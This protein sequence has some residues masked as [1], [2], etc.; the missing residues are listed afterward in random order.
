MMANSKKKTRAKQENILKK[1]LHVIPI[2][3]ISPTTYNLC[4]TLNNA[5]NKLK[6]VII[7]TMQ[8]EK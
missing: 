2:W 3:M 5:M 4:L 1:I 8:E 7:E 6:Q